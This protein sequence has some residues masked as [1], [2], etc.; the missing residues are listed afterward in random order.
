MPKKNSGTFCYPGGK[1]TIA[2]WIIDHFPDHTVYVEPFG[3]SASVLVQKPKSNVEV[4]NDLNSDCVA[5]FEAIKSHPDELERWVKNT[6]YSRE[7][8]EKWIKQ[9]SAGERA[10]DTVEQAG[11]FWF[12][13]TAS[14]GGDIHDGGGGFSVMK[15]ECK[16]AHYQPQKWQ[17][18]KDVIKHI[19]DR[20][21]NVQIEQLDYAELFD[22]YDSTEAFFYCD[23]PYVDVGD[24]YYQTEDGGFN[25]PRFC[26]ELLDLDGKWLV[27]YGEHIP[28]QLSD[29]HTVTRTK[30]ATMS[31][32]RP[33]ITERLIMNYNPND[34]AKFKPS[35]QSGLEAFE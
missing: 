4:Y 11:R 2:P 15:G 35:N 19:R 9:F 8:F 32:Q 5:F 24:D 30:E 10:N 14:F 26:E 18:K 34:V 21:F 27:S 6:P 7:L 22:K 12:L 13:T 28:A 29:Y 1:T 20:F 3:G 33:E 23:P 25:H 17:R 31:K 16:E